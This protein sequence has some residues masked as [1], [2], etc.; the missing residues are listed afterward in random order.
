MGA[1]EQGVDEERGKR[2]LR[3]SPPSTTP[4]R[5]ARRDPL[6]AVRKR[7]VPHVRVRVAWDAAL[8]L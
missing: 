4:A 8:A 1:C 6:G 5:S 3:P 7:H 2:T